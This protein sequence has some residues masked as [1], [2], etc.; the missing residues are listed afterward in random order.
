MNIFCVGQ[1]YTE[2]AK[3]LGNKTPKEP[4]FFQ[5]A[6]SCISKSD[7]IKI[8]S[9]RIIHHEIELVIILGYSGSNISIDSAISHISQW[10]LGL[11]LTDRPRQNEMREK[12]LP[13]FD[14][15]CFPGSAVITE[16]EKFK[17]KYGEDATDYDLMRQT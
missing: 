16:P 6:S 12:G 9:G 7:L 4:I 11:D 3:E 10:C 1:N 14:S 5:K 17:W 15:K 2:H 8:P 13:W